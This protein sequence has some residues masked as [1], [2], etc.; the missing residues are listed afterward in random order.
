MVTFTCESNPF[1]PVTLTVV[2]VEVLGARERLEGATLSVKSGDG[3][4]R[5]ASAAP[6]AAMREGQHGPKQTGP[7]QDCV[8]RP[9]APQF[10]AMSRLPTFRVITCHGLFPGS[11]ISALAQ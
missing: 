9:A 7:K 8:L 10:A 2:D 6:A 4:R 11:Q 5:G 3:G 1:S